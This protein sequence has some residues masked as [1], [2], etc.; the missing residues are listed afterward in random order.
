MYLVYLFREKNTGHVI[1][2]GSSAR[3]AERLKEHQQALL[4]MKKQSSIHQ[5]MNSHNL[6]L[7]KDVIVEWVDS[8]ED[9]HEMVDLEEQYY[10]KYKPDGYLLNDRPGEDR[11]G[12]FNPRR[13]KVTC[14]NDGKIFS[15]VLEAA[16]YYD[17]PRT[18]VSNVAHGYRSYVTKNGT[19]YRFELGWQR[20]V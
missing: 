3:P 20:I 19:R 4:G 2:V 15:S 17:I 8:G 9:K 6:K 5:Y 12:H 18:S 13:R 1:Y 7:Y 16:K 10:S 11:G 14:L